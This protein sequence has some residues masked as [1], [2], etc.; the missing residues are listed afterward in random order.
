MRGAAERHPSPGGGGRPGAYRGR[1]DPAV[2]ADRAAV[3]G[4]HAGAVEAARRIDAG[5]P[6]RRE[7]GLAARR[8]PAG[9]TTRFCTRTAPAGMSAP[10]AGV[11]IRPGRSHRR[12]PAVGPRQGARFLG[13]AGL[14]EPGVL[15][16]VG[17]QPGE[18]RHGVGVRRADLRGEGDGQVHGSA[19]VVPRHDRPGRPR[20][21]D[22]ADGGRRAGRGTR[23]GEGDAGRDRDVR[24]LATT[25]GSISSVYARVVVPSVTRRSSVPLGRGAPVADG[26]A[27]LRDRTVA[28]P[29]P[30]ARAHRVPPRPETGLRAPGRLCGG[31]VRSGRGKVRGRLG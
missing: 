28:G 10:K 9:L 3:A 23:L 26:G 7:R 6:G 17:E 30:D 11:T 27:P 8:V 1:G 21:A 25:F 5:G 2:A 31:R 14:M 24:T 12:R 13:S 4:V 15:P 18:G 29:P 20:R 16:G 19:G 22:A